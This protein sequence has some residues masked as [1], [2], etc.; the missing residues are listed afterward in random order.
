[1]VKFQFSFC[2]SYSLRCTKHENEYFYT[3]SNCN[4][5]LY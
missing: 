1:M 3:N 2:T 5:Y 4:T